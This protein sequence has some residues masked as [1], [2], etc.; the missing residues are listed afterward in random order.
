MLFGTVGLT[1]TTPTPAPRP[2]GKLP[3][4]GIP[5]RAPS[6][7]LSA[8]ITVAS[9][10][11]CSR[12]QSSIGRV[13][14]HSL[15]ALSRIRYICDVDDDGTGDPRPVHVRV[16]SKL[17]RRGDHISD[18]P[19]D[20][21]SEGSSGGT[22]LRRGREEPFVR[23]EPD[24]LRLPLFFD[25]RTWRACTRGSVGERTEGELGADRA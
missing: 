6:L 24:R 2:S 1:G 13:H 15:H 19:T 16:L 21:A 23:V 14:V 7:S 9:T 4:T 10:F 18:A 5:I 3:G 22:G 20:A 8:V 11:S 25:A 17:D 12:S